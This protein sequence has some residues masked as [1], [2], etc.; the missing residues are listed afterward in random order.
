MSLDVWLTVDEDVEQ[1][2]VIYIREDGQS[3]PISRDEWDERFPNRVPITAAPV[4]G[5]AFDYNITHNLGK[6]ADEAGVYQHLWCPEE[7][8][9]TKA[10]ELI[11]PLEAGLKLLIAEPDRFKALNPSNGW[12]NYEGLVAFVAAYLKACEDYPYAT[13]NVWR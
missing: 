2:P 1:A 5:R 11:E 6:M 12:G 3:R 10:A 8:G 7:I 13:V 4:Q 9:I